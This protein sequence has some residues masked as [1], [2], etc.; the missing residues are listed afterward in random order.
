[1]ELKQFITETLTQ[2]AQGVKD[3]QYNVSELGAK[4]NPAN[5]AGFEGNVPR[6][7]GASHSKTR[8]LCDVEFNVAL[9]NDKSNSTGTGVGVLFGALN[10][11]GKHENEDKNTEL[12]SIRFNV[13]MELP[14][15]D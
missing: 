6:T 4:I 13:I 8:I 5:V 1:M 10:L 3:A 7:K 9:T 14:T 15:Q 2:I 12:T 11:G